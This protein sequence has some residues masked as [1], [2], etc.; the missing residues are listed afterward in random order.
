MSAAVRVCT[1]HIICSGH[2]WCPGHYLLTSVLPLLKAMHRTC[3]FSWYYTYSIHLHQL[4][5]DFHWCNTHHTQNSKHTSYFKVCHGSGRPSIF[6]AI[7]TVS[8]HSC[9]TTHSTRADYMFKSAVPWHYFMSDM[10]LPY[11]LKL[12]FVPVR[13]RKLK[14]WYKEHIHNREY[15]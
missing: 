5:V 14:I 12:P 8:T 13:G 6:N 7:L 10:L 15:N 1:P 3:L 9:T 11:F 2:A 4:A